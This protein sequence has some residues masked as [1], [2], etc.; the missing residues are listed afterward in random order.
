MTTGYTI[1]T[2]SATTSTSVDSGEFNVDDLNFH[3]TTSNTFI[4]N[5][6]GGEITVESFE[7]KQTDDGNFIEVVKREKPN[8]NF[9][10]TIYPPQEQIDRVW[11]EIYG[12]T[13]EDGRQVLKL[14]QTIEG[15]VTPG[16]YVEESIDFDE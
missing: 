10:L 6:F 14:I 1:S 9:T 13:S 11:K 15:S 7:F 2:D 16:H 5:Q 4:F 8:P 3:T 12:I